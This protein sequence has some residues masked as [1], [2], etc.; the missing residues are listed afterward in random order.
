MTICSVDFQQ[1]PIIVLWFTTQCSVPMLDLVGEGSPTAAM[2][3]KRSTA[4][5]SRSIQHEDTSVPLVGD[6]GGGESRTNDKDFDETSLE[7]ETRLL[8]KR[9]E[10]VLSSPGWRM[11]SAY[12]RWVRRAIG[13]RPGLKRT[14][15][16]LLNWF[17]RQALGIE[18]TQ[19]RT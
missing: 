15:D 2:R 18:S 6:A 9:L 7:A 1:F 19:S 16:R 3:G 14:H 13:R 11:L 5:A 8:R 4:Q 12:R 17:F 10:L